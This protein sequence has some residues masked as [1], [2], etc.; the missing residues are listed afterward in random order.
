MLAAG[1]SAVA[2]NGDRVDA[3]RQNGQDL[4]K[5]V[6]E[7]FAVPDCTIRALHPK[8]DNGSDIVRAVTFEKLVGIRSE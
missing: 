2:I 3:A 8:T 7:G 1:L 5:Q 4:F 6:C